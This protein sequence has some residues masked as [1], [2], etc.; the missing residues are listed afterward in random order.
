MAERLHLVIVDD[1]R[2]VRLHLQL[3]VGADYECHLADSA[4]AGLALARKLDPLPSAILLDV[5]MPGL[6]GIEALRQ[7]KAD[8][9]MRDVPVVM[10]T[11]RGEEETV[12]TCRELGCAGFVTKPVQTPELFQVLR[13]VAPRGLSHG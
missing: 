4:E 11:T 1:S 2:T 13:A 12:E 5:R 9:R 10:V 8:A 6:G 7:L 3:L